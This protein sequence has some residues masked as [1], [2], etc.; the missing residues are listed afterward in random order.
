MG[1]PYGAHKTADGQGDYISSLELHLPI[2]GLENHC[3]SAACSM[4]TRAGS[5]KP[6]VPPLF[7][8]LRRIGDPVKSV[9]LNH[10]KPFQ[11]L[12]FLDTF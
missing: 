8:D 7:S 1:R 5:A 11:P 2:L 10:G 9:R 6:G 12:A 3:R 4:R